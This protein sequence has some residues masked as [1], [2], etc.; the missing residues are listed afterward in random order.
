M[1][2]SFVAPGCLLSSAR[3][4]FRPTRSRPRHA[5][6]LPARGSDLTTVS[7]REGPPEER[8]QPPLLSARMF[9]QHFNAVAISKGR[10]S[11][12]SCFIQHQDTSEVTQSRGAVVSGEIHGRSGFMATKR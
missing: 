10:T 11:H 1:I 6:Y 2:S 8:W 3:A 9:G 4:Q 5:R 12:K 7:Q